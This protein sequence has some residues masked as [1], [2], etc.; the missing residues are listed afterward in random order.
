M[1]GAL[2]ARPGNGQTPS[3]TGDLWAPLPE[4]TRWQYWL[5]QPGHRD[6]RGAPVVERRL[7]GKFSHCMSC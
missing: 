3:A 5:T 6:R 4:A 1:E 2:A 7:K